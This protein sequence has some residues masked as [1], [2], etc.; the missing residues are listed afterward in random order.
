L[1]LLAAIGIAA[2]AC[3]GGVLPG[4]AY[5]RPLISLKGNIR[6]SGGLAQAVRPFVSVVWTDPLQRQPDVI[7][8]ANRLRSAV[9]TA[10]DTYTLDIFRPPPPDAVFDLVDASGE[11]RS[12]LGFGEL[13]IIDDEDGDGEFHIA[14]PRAT[15]DGPD[16]Y[17][18][19][20]ANVLTYVALPFQPAGLTSPLTLPGQTGYAVVNYVCQGQLSASTVKVEPQDVEM[21]LQPSHDFP[22]VRTCRTSHGP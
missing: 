12:K 22:D 7:M 8:P 15:I 19:G 14:G 2:S 16:Q 18:A 13:V 4:N 9:D 11:A 1:V 3:G 21:V 20:S 17:L 10:A 5:D 6:P